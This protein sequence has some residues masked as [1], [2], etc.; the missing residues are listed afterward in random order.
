[1][2]ETRRWVIGLMAAIMI[3]GVG[4]VDARAQSAGEPSGRDSDRV[5]VRDISGTWEGTFRLDSAWN[6]PQ[7]PTARST[8]ARI[9]FNPVGDA[10]PT[11][12]SARSVHRGTF[13]ID[14]SRFGFTLSTQEALGWSVTA[15]SMR[16]TLNPTV[17]HGLVEVHGTFRGDTIVGTWRYTS[18]PG[19]ATGA[20][21]IR[22][23]S[24]R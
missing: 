20:F 12:S 11:T 17:D 24:N 16:A 6:L 13:E 8:V 1:M 2:P 10:S 18:D 22:K 7:R 9:Q 14:F 21:T 4:G 3:A 15:D 19:G 5:A 23:T